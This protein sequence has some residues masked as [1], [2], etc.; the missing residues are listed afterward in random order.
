MCACIKQKRPNLP[1]RAPMGY[2]STGRP[3]SMSRLSPPGVKQYI[4]VFADHF[5]RFAQAYPH[6]GYPEKLHHNQSK[7]FENKLFSKLQQLAGHSWRTPY[8]PQSN[9]VER[10]NCTL[11]QMMRTLP[12]DSLSVENPIIHHQLIPLTYSTLLV[13]FLMCLLSLSLRVQF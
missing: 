7:E 4:L 10:L 6:F 12:V 3:F 5:M 11:L 9:P 13:P 1:Q 8:H 2:I